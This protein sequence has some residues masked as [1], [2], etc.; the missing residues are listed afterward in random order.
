MLQAQP[1]RTC[2]PVKDFNI[3]ADDQTH[4]TPV[5]LPKRAPAIVMS[6]DTFADIKT[7]LE[8]ACR[9]LGNHCSKEMQT[10]LK[11]LH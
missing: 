10:L 9:V 6:A 2:V 7:E 11:A 4:G 8:Q 1:E 3:C 5:P